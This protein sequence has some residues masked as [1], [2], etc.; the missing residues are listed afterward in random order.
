MCTVQAYRKL[1]LTI[2]KFFEVLDARLL[3]KFQIYIVAATF[4]S[5]LSVL[6]AYATGPQLKRVFSREPSALQS[7]PF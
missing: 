6:T 3:T 5:K 7:C 1:H 4:L 2:F